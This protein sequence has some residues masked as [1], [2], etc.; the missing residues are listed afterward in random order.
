LPAS[1]GEFPLTLED[2]GRTLRYRGGDGT[3]LGKHEVAE[4]LRRLVQQGIG[5]EGVET[6]ES[7]LEDIFVNLVEN[8][9]E[10]A[11]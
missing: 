4:V 5:F 2:Q 7:S 1:L 11:P 8:R 6:S 9:I 10:V 3:G